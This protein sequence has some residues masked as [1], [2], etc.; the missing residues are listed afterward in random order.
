MVN[1]KIVKWIFCDVYFKIIVGLESQ[2]SPN[3]AV[4]G[5]RNCIF[6]C[7][8]LFFISFNILNTSLSKPSEQR[9]L[10]ADQ[11]RLSSYQWSHRDVSFIQSVSQSGSHSFIH[12]VSQSFR[13][14]F[15]HSFIH[16]FSQSVS[17]S[18]I[19]TRA[20]YTVF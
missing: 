2:P 5:F 1:T 18:V 8:N 14:S 7:W 3:T 16:S 6:F 10:E 19:V 15:I 13:H 12:S 11:S 9:L 17:Q 4:S 20:T